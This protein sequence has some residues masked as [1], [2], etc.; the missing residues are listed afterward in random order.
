MRAGYRACEFANQV[1]YCGS[2]RRRCAGELERI[3]HSAL[4]AQQV[5]SCGAVKT[6]EAQ[7]D[8]SICDRIDVVVNGQE[9]ESPKAI[10]HDCLCGPTAKAIARVACDAGEV[11][12]LQR[13]PP[14]HDAAYGA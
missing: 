3:P 1:A 6:F 9:R 13:A 4:D 12:K 5:F 7:A 8:Y 11:V 14:R 10:L 2:T